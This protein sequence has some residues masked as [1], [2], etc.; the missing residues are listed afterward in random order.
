MIAKLMFYQL[1]K[2]MKNYQK[3]TPQYHHLVIT[4]RWVKG[5]CLTCMMSLFSLISA[6]AAVPTTIGYN[7]VSITQQ[8]EQHIQ[9]IVVDKMGEP[10]IGATI[11]E[12]GGSA[13]T[14]SDAEGKFSLNASKG[15]ILVCSYVG[16]NSQEVLAGTRKNLVITLTEQSNSLSELVVIGYGTQRKGEVASSI[17]TVQA[18]DFNFKPTTNAADLIK[19][20]VAGLEITTPD[21]NPLGSTQISLRG[22]TTLMASTAPLVLIDG[23]PGDLNSVSPDDI[24]QIDVLKDGSAA[25]IYGTR[26]TNGVILITTK[27]ARGELPTEITF[28][29]SLSFQSITK[30]LDFF[31]AAGYRKL[32]AQKLPGTVD[33]GS[34][35]D[36]LDQVTRTP[37]TQIYSISLRGGTST[38]NYMASFDYRDM[39]GLIKKTENVMY[40]PRL[41]ITHRMFNNLIKLDAG[42]SGYKQTYWGGSDDS[43]GYDT[44]VY[45]AALTFNP[46][47][48]VRDANGNYTE[49]PS[50]TA[51]R[52]PVALL[53]EVDGHNWGT[54]MRMFGAVTVSPINGLN[55]KYLYSSSIYNEARGYYQTSK[56]YESYRNGRTG[57]ASRGTNRTV[58]D[59]SEFTVDYHKT[60]AKDHSLNVLA[61]YSWQRHGYQFYWMQNWDFPTDAYS[62]NNMGA[63]AALSNGEAKESSTRTE[64]TLIGFFTRF[65]YAYKGRYMLSGSIRHEGSSKFG[66]NHKWGNFPS[67]SAAW[68]IKDESFMSNMRWISQLKLRAGYGETGTEPSSPY[69]S[70]N[71]LSLGTYSYYNGSWIKTLRPASNANPD[72]KWEKKQEYNLGL[73]FG[74]LQDRITGSIDI[75]NRKTKDLIWNYSVPS[76][77]YLYSSMT[78][79]GGSIRNTG[80]EVSITT[81]PVVTPNFQW[82]SAANFSTNKSKLISLSSSK[83]EANNYANEGWVTEPIQ[84][85]SHRLRVGKSIGD[86]WGF[87]SIG[88]DDSGHWIIQGADG[89]AK[90]IDNQTA[91]DKTYIGNG[92]PKYYVNWNNNIT[93][94][95]FD[96]SISMRGAFDFDILNLA[97]LQY[98]SPS[99]LSRGNVLKDTFDKKYGRTALAIDQS[100]QYVSYYIEKGNYWKIDN[101]TLGYTFDFAKWLKSVRVFATI[102]NVA[103]IT[104]YSGI[105]PE[106]GTSGLTPGIDDYYR[107]PATRT[108][109]FGLTVKL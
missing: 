16:Y 5:T 12:K 106:V 30:K 87:K 8:D 29:S 80:I 2:K 77:P 41:E 9:G 96:F 74:F 95:K 51:Y 14:V 94:K 84:T 19:G 69:M 25:A 27:Q 38:T 91:D 28:N 55:L 81:I 47:S 103:T 86:F 22:T 90:S 68:N 50:R 31:D 105:D 83:Y 89:K 82:V 79:N 43:N 35:V 60:F 42:I 107:Y 72:L 58:D 101:I 3:K 61:G 1:N 66:D 26:G 104:G 18:A 32:V 57:F 64:N 97:E 98:G 100:L 24:E 33:E 48:P 109:S 13:A 53:N 85:Y 10:L 62:F 73:D 78:A 71:T 44:A 34:D 7:G 37:L 70:L 39:N 52:N 102:T 21:A 23:I 15:A 56:H 17:A 93:W 11:K 6:T 54:F 76:P 63:G 40:H 75:Y 46:T 36:Y 4:R 45:A 59:L 99:M 65:N 67:I 88:I 49:D 20:K 92:I 108:Y